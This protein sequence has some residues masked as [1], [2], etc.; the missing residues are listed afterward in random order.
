M[1]VIVVVTVVV[2][3]PHPNSIQID[4]T[5]DDGKKEEE[6]TNGFLAAA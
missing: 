1:Y 4:W 5:I 6:A 3:K 2:V